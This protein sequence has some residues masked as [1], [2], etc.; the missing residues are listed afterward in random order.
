MLVIGCGASS[1]PHC[2]EPM[3]TSPDGTSENGGVH[4]TQV[5]PE[6]LR[7]AK[8]LR[9]CSACQVRWACAG[10]GVAL[11]LIMKRPASSVT[12]WPMIVLELLSR[13]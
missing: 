11:Q 13:T 8:R 3:S 4:I 12:P 2:G 7:I 1:L 9:P 5:P 6:L 10:V